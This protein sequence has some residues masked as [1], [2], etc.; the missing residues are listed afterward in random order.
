MS[1]S[2]ADAAREEVIEAMVQSMEVYGFN[3]SYGRLYGLLV[4]RILYH[5]K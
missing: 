4:T 5:D 1:Q 3:R 2:D